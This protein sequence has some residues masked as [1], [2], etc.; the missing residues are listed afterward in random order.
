MPALPD[1]DPALVLETARTAIAD[2]LRSPPGIA[3]VRRV[4]AEGRPGSG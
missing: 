2:Y 4:I 1:A 3:L